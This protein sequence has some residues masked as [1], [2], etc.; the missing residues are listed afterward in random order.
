MRRSRISIRS[1]RKSCGRRRNR[2]DGSEVD[3][4]SEG[5]IFREVDLMD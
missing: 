2:S 1:C 4:S 3:G 5:N